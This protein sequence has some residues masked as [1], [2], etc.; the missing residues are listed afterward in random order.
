MSN[1][2]R[3]P[4][5]LGMSVAANNLIYGSGSI[6]IDGNIICRPKEDVVFKDIIFNEEDMFFMASNRYIAEEKENTISVV[7]TDWLTRRHSGIVH[8]DK[9]TFD[10]YFVREES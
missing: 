6:R 4:Y 9:E 3:D 7:Y 5:Y 2:L 1:I 10:K 8:L